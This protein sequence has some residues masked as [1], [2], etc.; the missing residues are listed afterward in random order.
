[1]ASALHSTHVIVAWVQP[2]VMWASLSGSLKIWCRLPTG[3]LLG[4]PLSVSF[5]R[6]VTLFL[7]LFS[8]AAASS[9]NRIEFPY[10]FDIFR[11]SMPR[12]LGDLVKSVCGSGKTGLPSSL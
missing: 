10:D 3:Q 7:I 9:L 1:M 4:S 8:T 11:L 6:S 2:C 5:G 12:S